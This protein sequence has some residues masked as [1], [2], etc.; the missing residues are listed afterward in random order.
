VSFVS[1]RDVVSADV[2]LRGSLCALQQCGL[3][4]GDAVVLFRQERFSTATGLALH[5]HEELGRY[6]I[7][8][9]FW[10]QSMSGSP[11]T[12]HELRDACKEHVDKQQAGQLSQMF[13]GQTDSIYGKL[14]AARSAAL[15]TPDFAKLDAEIKELDRRSLKRQPHDRSD[16]RARAFYVDLS[17][18]GTSWS[19]PSDLSRSDCRRAL[20]DATNDYA[21]QKQQMENPELIENEPLRRAVQ[22]LSDKPVFAKQPHVTDIGF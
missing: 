10:E 1:G 11:V 15:G 3:I 21:V 18:D 13:E 17:D 7:L 4:L 22:E 8:L 6:K 12:R 5:G 19:T 9:R 20:I 2:L 16:Q 14:L